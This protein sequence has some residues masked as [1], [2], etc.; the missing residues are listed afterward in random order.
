MSKYITEQMFLHS[1]VAIEKHIHNNFKNFGQFNIA[2][3]L[4]QKVI[5]P[6]CDFYKPKAIILSSGYRGEQLNKDVGGDPKSDHCINIISNGGAAADINFVGLN[7]KQLFNDIFTGKI[8]QPNGK[9]LTDIIDQLIYEERHTFQGIQR[10][11][12]IGHRNI[13]RHQFM[14]SLDGKTYKTAVHTI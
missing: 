12:H 3:Y 6:I 4:C 10:W 14:I 11:V 2:S 1:D 8:K 7:P 13:P 9:P 5:D